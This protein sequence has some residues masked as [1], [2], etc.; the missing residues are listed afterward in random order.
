MLL[1][2]LQGSGSDIRSPFL[3]PSTMDDT[4]LLLG[5]VSAQLIEMPTHRVRTLPLSRTQVYFRK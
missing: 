3:Q 5:H 1:C 2:F 4:R